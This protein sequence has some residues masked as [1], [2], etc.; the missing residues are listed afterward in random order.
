MSLRRTNIF[1]LPLGRGPSSSAR[2]YPAPV[3][4]DP[5]T[6][7]T[8]AATRGFPG[9][10]DAPPEAR[11]HRPGAVA[12]QSGRVI[13]TGE[14]DAMRHRYGND[15]ATV[16][17]RPG[18]LLLPGL[19]NAH[20]HLDLTALG[21]RPSGDDF[22][23]WVT[24]LRDHLPAGGAPTPRGD[25][26]SA[27]SAARGA[28]MSLASGVQAVGD[29]ARS[30]T[31]R[32]HAQLAGT[33]YRELLGL[34]SPWDDAALTWLH[35][36]PIPDPRSPVP[37]EGLQPH[38]PYSAGPALY[39]AAAR[40]GRPVSTHLAETPEEL[41]FVRDGDGPFRDLLQRLGKW[42]PAFARHYGHGQTPVQWMAP[43]LRQTPWLLAHCNYLTDDDITLIAATGASVAYCPVASDYFGHA[44]HPYRDLLAAGVNVALGTDSILCQPPGEPQPLGL[45]P[46]MRHLFRRDAADPALLLRMATVHGRR[47]LNLDDTVTMLVALPFDPADATDPL[48]QVLLRDEPAT[49]LPLHRE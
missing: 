29:I 10:P 33:T 24:T 26:W 42:D 11:G 37:A 40:S 49:S 18:D 16:I 41:R 38:A 2:F 34:G 3:P 45:V 15:A 8:A 20:A 7:Y 28:A 31:A 46:Q 19:V 6:L 39:H 23:G 44:N 32:R 14:A 21:P 4:D 12:V 48:K 13:A 27:A 5:I 43:Y 35:S 30:D 36:S 47:A 9:E 22:I 17:D 25:A 1:T